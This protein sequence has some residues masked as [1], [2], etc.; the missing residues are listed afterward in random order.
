VGITGIA[1][2]AREFA[3]AIGIDGPIERDAAG[4]A[5]VE[6]GFHREEKIFGAFARGAARSSGGRNGSEA[7]DAD[8]RRCGAAC[9]AWYSKNSILPEILPLA[10]RVPARGRNGGRG[11]IRAAV[12]SSIRSDAART[13]ERGTLAGPCVRAMIRA[14]RKERS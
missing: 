11:A 1:V 3:A 10:E 14:N 13:V 6:N 2:F 8:Q 5:F 7:G 4:F 12:V 9:S